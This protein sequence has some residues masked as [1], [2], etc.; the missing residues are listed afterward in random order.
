MISIVR[1]SDFLSR[2]GFRPS[3]ARVGDT[4]CVSP[5]E[6]QERREK[7]NSN[8]ISRC[9]RRP[10]PLIGHNPR[11]RRRRRDK[12]GRSEPR[13][14]CRD[15]TASGRRLSRM[16]LRAFFHALDTRTP[17]RANNARVFSP[18]SHVP[19]RWKSPRSRFSAS[20]APAATL[21]GV[22]SRDPSGGNA[23]PERD[24]N[25]VLP[26]RDGYGRTLNAD[27]R[28]RCLSR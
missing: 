1:F 21:P 14:F 10:S 9:D 20:V 11:R 24:W 2:V 8:G 4:R 3:M 15:C 27:K 17:R 26:E 19:I 12:T 23:T 7:E 13:A 6:S 22:R 25:V 18:A 28:L 16:H 5:I